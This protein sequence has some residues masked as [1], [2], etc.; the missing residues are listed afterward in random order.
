M[1]AAYCISRMKESEQVKVFQTLLDEPRFSAVLYFYAGFTKLANPGVQNIIT[2][3][4]FTYEQSSKL[5]LLN[6]M[7]CFFE[8]QIC[9]QSLYQKVIQRL[10]GELNVCYIT[11]SPL[12]CMAI[13]YFLAFVL[14]N[15][16]LSVDL[17][18]CSFDEQLLSVL[19]EELSKYAEDCRDGFH[20]V[21]DLNLNGNK[22]RDNG[23]ACIA[24][25]LRT[26]STL[27][28]LQIGD[29][30]V[31]DKGV[32][33]LSTALAANS[34]VEHLKVTWIC[35]HPDSTLKEIGEGVRKS[36]LR[37]L[38]LKMLMLLPSSRAIATVEKAK[39]WLKCLKAGGQELIQSQEESHLENLSLDGYYFSP[40]AEI[41]QMLKEHVCQALNETAAKVNFARSKGKRSNSKSH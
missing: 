31:T 35:T 41:T 4:N 40:G 36:K 28:K 1:L 34:S 14:K 26:N 2:R 20:G 38:E 3:N 13:A 7:H 16:E 5:S 37:L 19:V 12:D 32:Q 25:V 27:K 18:Y 10:N 24:T 39:Y 17:S 22:I 23:M 8:A 6:Y 15:T 11:M 21:K 30:T 9:D 29:T 33:I